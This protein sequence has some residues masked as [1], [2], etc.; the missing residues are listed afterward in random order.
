MGVKDS[1]NS[2]QEGGNFVAEVAEP[3]PTEDSKHMLSH[4]LKGH[5]LQASITGA[6][7]ILEVLDIKRHIIAQ[8]C[9]KVRSRGEG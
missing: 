9:G 8:P 2:L 4:R 6:E 5:G 1:G 7:Q 3:G